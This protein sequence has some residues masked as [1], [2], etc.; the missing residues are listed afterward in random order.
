MRRHSYLVGLNEECHTAQSRFLALL[1]NTTDTSTL[2]QIETAFS[3]ESVSKEF[4]AEYLR[5]FEAT[6]SALSALVKKDKT[7]QADFE[8]KHGNTSDFTEKLDGVS[9]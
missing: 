1:Q 4:F 5:L 8:A 9:R 7:L 3:V 2:A 6:E